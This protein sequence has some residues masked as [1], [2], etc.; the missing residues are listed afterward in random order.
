MCLHCGGI[1]PTSLPT[2]SSLNKHTQQPLNAMSS[3]NQ[4]GPVVR[5]LPGDY[6]IQAKTPQ[7]YLAADEAQP[8][9]PKKVFT[10]PHGT[11]APKVHITLVLC[12]VCV[13]TSV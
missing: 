12:S 1:I 6:L 5:L 9:L 10:L 7:L 11:L 3:P 8:L 4:P 2:A 13:L